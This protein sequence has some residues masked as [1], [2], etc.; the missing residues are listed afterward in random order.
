MSFCNNNSADRCPGNI[1]GNPMN[2]LCEKVCVQVKKIYDAAVVK[3][4]SETLSVTVTNQT[5]A[6]PATPLTFVSAKSTSNTGTITDLVVTPLTDR[7]GLSRV[8]ATVSIPVQVTYT[9][10]NGATGSGTTTV[11]FPID[12]VMCVPTGSVFPAQLSA[13]VALSANIGNWVSGADFTITACITVIVKV[14]ADVNLLIPSY[15]PCK[16]PDATPYEQEVCAGVFDQPL[17]PV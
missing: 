6:N 1:N 8:Q 9:D 11:P 17:Y 14:T 12:I 16:L 7:Q 13:G 10:A 4:G 2:G 5:P 3:Q 15:G